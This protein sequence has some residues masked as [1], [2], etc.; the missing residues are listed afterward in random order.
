MF[1]VGG[2]GV[3]AFCFLNEYFP[4]EF[5]HAGGFLINAFLFSLLFRLP[6]LLLNHHSLY[7]CRRRNSQ[8]RSLV[9]FPFHLLILVCD[10]S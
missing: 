1:V 8:Q 5:R 2:E 7:L 9:G 6:V 4:L 3:F 10:E